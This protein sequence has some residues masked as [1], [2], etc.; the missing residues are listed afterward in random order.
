MDNL[1]E[2]AEKIFAL[3]GF[4]PRKVF[5]ERK[6][7]DVFGDVLQITMTRGRWHNNTRATWPRRR[8][9]RS[10]MLYGMAENSLRAFL[11]R[12]VEKRV[13]G[14]TLKAKAAVLG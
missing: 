4:S 11:T 10:A 14:I 8:A 9:E 6:D 7:S 3:Y 13:R 12:G 1:Q 5:A 2:Q